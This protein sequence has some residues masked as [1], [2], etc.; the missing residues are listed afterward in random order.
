MAQDPQ[1]RRL[2]GRVALVTGAGRGIGRCIAMH[3]ARAGATLVAAGRNRSNLDAVVES[4]RSTG[5]RA[6]AAVLDVT[7]EDAICR[8]VAWI[9]EH[10]GRLDILVNN[11]G[12]T[13]SAPLSETTTADWDRVMRVNARG[14]FILC[15]QA[16]G[17]MKRSPHGRIINIAS[18]VAIKGYANQSAYTASKHALRGMS[19]ALA[20]ELR[21][22]GIR[23]HV[24]CP[25]GVATDMVGQVRPD[26]PPSTLMAPDEIA[27]IV[28]YLAAHD[29]NAVIDEVHVRR[30]ASEPWFIS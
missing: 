19:M 5:G 10:L 7:D 2:D 18:V 13:H 22:T 23:V 14:P 20:E 25:G 4:I 16:L 24:V 28:T 15:R 1:R 6:E 21:D 30:A 17:L 9:D 8:A 29:G 27:E 3:L 11:A 12:V 26:I